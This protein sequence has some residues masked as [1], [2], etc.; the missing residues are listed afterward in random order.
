[1]RFPVWVTDAVEIWCNKISKISSCLVV[2]I[3]LKFLSPQSIALLTR[4]EILDW[5]LIL[6]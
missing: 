2:K 5:H 3:L 6:H 1:M 4:W